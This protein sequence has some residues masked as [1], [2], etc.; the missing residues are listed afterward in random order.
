MIYEFI[1]FDLDLLR[2]KLVDMA[3]NFDKNRL[4]HVEPNVK[5]DVEV[6]EAF[7]YCTFCKSV[8]SVIPSALFIRKTLFDLSTIT[9]YFSDR[10]SELNLTSLQVT[11]RSELILH[12]ILYLRFNSVK[13]VQLLSL[14]TFLSFGF[15]YVKF[16]HVFIVFIEPISIL[17]LLYFELHKCDHCY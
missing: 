2:E 10:W 12:E 7:I 13:L 5:V 4:K 11:Q 14:T 6:D 16:S 9:P 3:A 15:F 1:Q 17:L 8:V